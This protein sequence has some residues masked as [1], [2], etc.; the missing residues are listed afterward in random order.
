M[1][2]NGKTTITTLAKTLNVSPAT[3]SRA[4]SGQSGRSAD[5]IR[6][7]AQKLNFSPNLNARN[8]RLSQTRTIG[9]L[10]TRD[11]SIA[12]YAQL[13]SKLEAQL[14][15]H[16]KTMQLS[17]SG[18]DP[19]RERCCLEA[20]RGNRVDGII[21]GPVFRRGDMEQLEKF[22]AGSNIPLIGF[23]CMDDLPLHHITVDYRAG[24]RLAV[25]HLRQNGH[26]D[27]V[28]LGC[29][30]SDM[31]E[32]AGTR[33]QGF[34]EAMVACGLPLGAHSIVVTKTRRRDG[35]EAVRD[36]IAGGKKIPTAFFCHNDEI[37]L[38]AS[39]ALL[40]AGFRIPHDISLVGFDNQ[41][42][43]EWNIP[44][45][46]SVTGEIDGLVDG[47]VA[48]ITDPPAKKDAFRKQRLTPKLMERSSVRRLDA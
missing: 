36:W 29:P 32:I 3:I 10:I 42:E 8:L 40:Q 15:R 48:F 22:S 39:F 17:I 33:R 19:E 30:P 21:A 23:S 47:L 28:Y 13:V 46:T 6:A 43:C 37:A 14:A 38:G 12:W 1:E 27:I 34:E 25:E 18:Q 9:V 5:K 41:P 20:F 4:L 35:W 2:D 31:R 26:R 45:L 16:G 24:A 7:L 44:A 11:I